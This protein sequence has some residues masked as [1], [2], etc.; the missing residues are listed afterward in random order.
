MGLW[1][2]TKLDPQVTE[3]PATSFTESI[4][5]AFK[6]DVPSAGFAPDFDLKA[7][8]Y[9][10]F[11]DFVGKFVGPVT[12]GDMMEQPDGSY[13]ALRV[14]PELEAKLTA[15]LD[16]AETETINELMTWAEA[17][18]V[19]YPDDITPSNLAKR[20]ERLEVARGSEADTQ[21]EILGRASTVSQVFGGFLGSAAAQFTDP[22]NLMTLPIGASARAGLLITTLVEAAINATIEGLQTPGRNRYQAMIG[23]EETSLVENMAVGAIFGGGIGLGMKA[24]PKVGKGA[25]R[26]SRTGGRAVA[27]FVSKTL[28][29]KALA[30]AAKTDPSPDVRLLAEAVLQDLADETAAV[31]NPSPAA[32]REHESRASAAAVSAQTGDALMIPDRPMQAVPRGSIING[33]IEEVDPRALLVQPEVFQFKSDTV[34]PG[35]VTA[36]LLKNETWLSERAGVVMVYEYAD[37]SRAIVDGHQRTA[38]A[39]RIMD[40][41]PSQSIKLAARVFREADGFSTLDIRVAAALT[42]IAQAADGMTTKMAV[43]AAKVLRIRPEAIKDLPTGPGITRAQELYALSDEAFD[44]VINRVLPPDQAALIG[45]LASDP[46][47]HG[48]LAKLLTRIAPDSQAQAESIINQALQAPVQRETISDLFGDQ[49]VTESLYLERAKVL[50]RTMRILRDDRQ[51]ARTL[52]EKSNRVETIGKN[53]LDRESNQA[54]RETMEKAL[55]AVAALAHRVGPI[56]EALNDAAK[57]YKNDGRLGDAADRVRAIV[58]DEIERNGLAGAGN[59]NAGRNA[60]PASPRPA[61]PDPL[62]GFSDLS[63]PAVQEQIEA[64]RIVPPDPVVRSPIE[65]D[66]AGPEAIAMPLDPAMSPEEQLA[67]IATMTAENQAIVQDFMAEVDQRFG[68][69]SGDNV[70]TPESILAK[71]TRPSI[72]AKKPW[73]TMAHIRDTYRFKTVIGD[74]RDVPAIFDALLQRG[75]SLVK[76]D[77]GKLF[78]PKEWG[79][80]IIAFDLRMPNGQLVEWYLPIR[81]LEAQKKAEG[82]LIFEDW[83]GKTEQELFDQNADY[84]AAIKRSFDGYNA[85]FESALTRAGLKSDEAAASWA[86]AEA[87]MLEAARKSANSSGMTTSAGVRGVENQTPSSARDAVNP[88][89]SQSE[90]RGVPSST[91]ASSTDI[92]STPSE[93]DMGGQGGLFEATKAGDQ[94]LMPG[95]TPITQADRLR[96]RANAPL[97]AD[98]RRSDTEIGG[99]F[100]PNDPARF[101]LFDLVPTGRSFDDEGNEI[102]LVM[103]RQQLAE[104]LDADN[105]AL[106]VMEVC[107][108]GATK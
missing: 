51:L 25:L 98:Q 90:A 46:A 48:P 68:T 44:L 11:H 77:T 38:L 103:T 10:P 37:G 14:P 108:K 63:G 75:I 57:R 31:T 8:A 67:R 52:T 17:N 40:R 73:F 2:P 58:R 47:M 41:D 32:T 27:E 24:A 56:S 88:P 55:T 102:P 4:G 104:E 107:I 92:T 30:T 83:R 22:V 76:V 95:V 61:P 19:P 87:S 12:P 34:A 93:S 49:E 81:E 1:K 101:D 53:R 42:N 79:W 86:K 66:N 15:G 3:G 71:A 99:L 59:G 62:E 33:E 35:G 64:T 105:E 70:K 28:D 21:N 20:R 94:K 39:N 9:Q 100:D 43:D 5:A 97:R 89:S 69:K 18:G 45:R 36:K 85:A 96:A 78:A 29:R 54:L 74:F 82:H 23:E 50:E 84:M 6:R 13:A 16:S 60:K 80:R 65:E 72:L 7:E 91:R 106:A 26:I